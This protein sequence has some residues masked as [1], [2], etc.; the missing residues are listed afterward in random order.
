MTKTILVIFHIFNRLTDSLRSSLLFISLLGLLPV[1]LYINKVI[2]ITTVI[3]P[4]TYP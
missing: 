4:T 2:I 3:R 1:T